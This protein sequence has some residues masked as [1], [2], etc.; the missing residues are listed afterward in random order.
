MNSPGVGRG[1]PTRAGIGIALLAAYPLVGCVGPV[2]VNVPLKL[3]VDAGPRA[4]PDERRPVERGDTC[5]VFL[6]DVRDDKTNLGRLGRT[7]VEGADTEGWVAEAI[8]ASATASV[9]TFVVSPSAGAKNTTLNVTLLKAYVSTI[10]TTKAATVALRIRFRHDD[11]DLGEVLYRG[12]SNG[13]FWGA[14]KG[15]AISALNDALREALVPLR[16]DILARCQG[17]TIKCRI[18]RPSPLSRLNVCASSRP[19]PLCWARNSMAA[20]HFSATS[21]T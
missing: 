4:A 2:P 20:T 9:V 6:A 17:N 10:I 13:A 15:E 18:E 8:K 3:D 16:R 19:L 11:R 21:K 12:N 1:M 7:A 5:A 14:G